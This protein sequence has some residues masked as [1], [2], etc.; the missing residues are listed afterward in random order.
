MAT[1]GSMTTRVVYQGRYMQVDWSLTSQSIEK[2]Q[3]TITFSVYPVGG[4][5]SY[6]TTG[7]S[8]LSVNGTEVK[9]WARTDMYTAKNGNTRWTGTYSTTLTHNADGTRSFSASFYTYIFYGDGNPD[10]YASCSGSWSLPTIERATEISTI[11]SFNLEDS[12]LCTFTPATDSFT[13]SLVVSINNTSIITAN[14]YTSGT[15]LTLTNAQIL[16]AYN[17]MGDAKSADFTFALTTYNNGTSIG[18]K[19]KLGTGTCAGT[20]RIRVSGSYKRALPWVKVNGTWKKALGFTRN[21][22]WK[23]GI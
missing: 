16:N 19:E 8:H 20:A 13:H 5:S 17:A 4:T 3:S 12:L 1:S 21:S 9:T 14:P 18:T 15:A 7:A 10:G 11:P 23:R 6:Y 22:T 2:N